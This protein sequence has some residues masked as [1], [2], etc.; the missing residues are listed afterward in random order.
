MMNSTLP[1]NDPQPA[2]DSSFTFDVV[3]VKDR[4]SIVEFVVDLHAPIA[5]PGNDWYNH[6]PYVG[7]Q[8]VPTLFASDVSHRLE[9]IDGVTTWFDFNELGLTIIR[10]SIKREVLLKLIP[11]NDPENVHDLPEVIVQELN[12]ALA[13]ELRRSG[14]WLL[15][16]R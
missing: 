6:R 11:S 12:L 8:C 2:D 4:S 9:N 13:G 14:D 10:I 15:H 5:K 1:S 3:T 7:V 16:W